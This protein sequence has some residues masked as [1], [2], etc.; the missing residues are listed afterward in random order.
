MPA[1]AIKNLQVRNPR[2]INLVER[3]RKHGAGRSLTE[4]A[5]NLISEAAEHRAAQRQ[6]DD[7]VAGQGEGANGEPAPAS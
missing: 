3:E 7:T 2:T 5:E 6:S 4:V 1:A